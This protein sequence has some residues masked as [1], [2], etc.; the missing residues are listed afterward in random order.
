MFFYIDPGTGSMLFT[1]LIGVFGTLIYSVKIFLAKAKTMF[2]GKKAAAISNR[3]IPFVIYSDDK[4]YWSIFAPICREL[5]KLDKEVLYLTASED[6][7]VFKQEFKNIKA[8]CIGKT[9]SSFFRLNY[10]CANIVISTTPSLGVF[11]WKRSKKVDYYVHVLHMANDVTLYRMF[12]LDYYDGVLLSGQYQAEDIR[13]LEK[14][15]GLPEKELLT[16]GIPYMDEMAKRLQSAEKLSDDRPRTVLL[17][18]S[19]GKSALFGAYG[20]K[21][22]DEL[23]KTGYRIV[24]RPHPQSFA[25][26]K[27]L[28][29]ELMAKYPD[30][31][32]IEWN[33]DN[34]N[35]EVLRRSDILIS[36]FSG[37]I[38]DFALVYGKPVIYT[39]PNF[40]LS[41]YDAWWLKKPVWTVTA[42]ERMGYQLT[43]ENLGSLKELIDDCLTNPRFTERLKEIKEE[44]WEHFGEGAER[45]VAFLQAKY[46]QLAAVEE[47]DG[48]K[49]EVELP[50]EES[51]AYEETA[52]SSTNGER[53]DEETDGEKGE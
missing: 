11:Q 52:I 22:I 14:L 20:G 37:I 12:G 7:P 32:Q 33:R 53:A 28:M 46:E 27:E 19:W 49:E 21:I 25:S 48:K 47:V 8:E 40:D 34:D 5:D 16:V 24:I 10:L 18:P 17:A 23:L 43:D 36:D 31:E 38:F 1:I 9:N 4:R 30:S 13:A 51:A 2:G 45:T 41:P 39:D 29:D 35:F 6:D 44:T 3:K 26:E 42:L 15:R 50:Q